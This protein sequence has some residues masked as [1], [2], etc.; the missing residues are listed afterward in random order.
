MDFIARMKKREF[1]EMGLKTIIAVLLG[2]I[3][4]FFMEA[5]IYNIYI[6]NIDKNQTSVTTGQVDYYIV[7]T[8]T[9]TYKVYLHCEDSKCWSLQYPELNKAKL[10]DYLYVGEMYN[11]NKEYKVVAK[12][13]S[14]AETTYEYS[15]ENGTALTQISKLTNK[16]TD[17]TYSVIKAG[18]TTAFKTDLSYDELT[19]LFN[20]GEFHSKASNN[21]IYREPNCFDI[22]LNWVHYVVMAIFLVAIIGVYAWRF[23]LISKE[24]KKI[25]K[26]FTKLGK[27]F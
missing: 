14:L 13:T 2:I 22:Y 19:K 6:K 18:E 21:I 5:M 10:D 20:V 26:R 8:K 25:E 3:V 11:A 23:V 4:I 15:T 12:D 7:E 1:I 27:I 16:D 17:F 24:Y 9:D